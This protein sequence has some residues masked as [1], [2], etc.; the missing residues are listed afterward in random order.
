MHQVWWDRHRL[1]G[2]EG[3]C[4]LNRDSRIFITK[5]LLYLC[6][7]TSMYFESSFYC[8]EYVEEGL[9]ETPLEVELIV[10]QN[11]MNEGKTKSQWFI[12]C[13]LGCLLRKGRVGIPILPFVFAGPVFISAFLS[14]RH[15]PTYI[16]CGLIFIYFV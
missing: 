2:Y 3:K 7:A 13:F 16:I 10:D 6:F 11:E 5:T 15:L 1:W 14:C 8:L 4:W 12:F 9:L